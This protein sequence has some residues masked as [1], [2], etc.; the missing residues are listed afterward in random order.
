LPYK[1]NYV[2]KFENSSFSIPVIPAAS[3]SAKGD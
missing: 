3:P 1:I 2:M